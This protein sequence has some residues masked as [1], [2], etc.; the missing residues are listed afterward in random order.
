MPTSGWVSANRIWKRCLEKQA[1]PR[2]RLRWSIKSRRRRSSRRCWRW[3]TSEARGFPRQPLHDRNRSQ[4]RSERGSPFHS[5]TVN[6]GRGSV[7]G[8][9][10]SRVPEGAIPLPLGCLPHSTRAR[11]F[12]LAPLYSLRQWKVIL[13]KN[14]RLGPTACGGQAGRCLSPTPRNLSYRC[15][16]SVGQEA[17]ATYT[18]GDRQ[19]GAKEEIH[20]N[21]TGELL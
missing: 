15:R 5:F 1:S 14:L 20:S 10:R 19:P 6:R 4:P 16:V 8:W 9:Y 7:Q 11:H 17:S 13:C 12:P 2:C 18:C 21:P 3:E